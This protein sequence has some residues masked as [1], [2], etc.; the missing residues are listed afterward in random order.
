MQKNEEVFQKKGA[1]GA[2]RGGLLLFCLFFDFSYCKSD[3]VVV[4]WLIYSFLDGEKC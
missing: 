2:A 4:K 1:D 3:R